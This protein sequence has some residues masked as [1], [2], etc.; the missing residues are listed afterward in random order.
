MECTKAEPAILAAEQMPAERDRLVA[1]GKQSAF[2]MG[3]SIFC[4]VAM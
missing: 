3:A 2:T 4:I 1:E